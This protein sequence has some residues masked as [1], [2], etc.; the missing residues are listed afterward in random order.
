MPWTYK[1]TTI[2]QPGTVGVIDNSGVSNVVNQNS[3]EVV[4]VGSSGGGVPK[5]VL[6]FTSIDDAKSTL[7]SGEGL[8]AV[9]RAFKPAKDTNTSPGSVSFV[10]VDPATQATYNLVN[11][12]TT[13]LSL[14][15]SQYG[16][17]ANQ[18]ST[19]VQAG[20]LKGL[21]AT[22]TQGTYSKT[23]DN[24]YKGALSIQYLGADASA[25]LTVS[26]SAGQMQGS[27]GA[28][29]AE[30]VAWTAPFATYTKVQDLINYINAQAG[31]S[32]TLMS[33]PSDQATA[34][35]FDD[36]TSQDCKTA[37]YT[38]TSTLD[39]LNAFYNNTGVVTSTRPAGVGTLP[40]VMTAPAY[41]TNGTDG[42]AAN[43]DWSDALATL[44]NHATARIITVLTDDASIHA[45]ADAH[46]SAMSLPGTNQNR[47]Q[48]A[49]GTLGETVSAVLNRASALNSK[50]TSLVYPGIQD[51]DPITLVNTTYAPY[52]VAAQSAGYLASLKITKALT[53]Q[54]IAAKGLEGNLQ[55]TLQSSDYDD[56]VN[57][58]VMAIKY[59]Q[60]QLTGNSYIFDRS[61]TTWLQDT[62]LTNVEISMVCNEDYVDL[63]VV[64]AINAYLVGL[65]GSP[66]GV[67][68][69]ISVID[70]EL[71][72]CFENGAIV[73]DTMKD[74]YSNITVSLANGAVTGGYNATI[75]APMNFFGITAG[76]NI[77]AKT[78][79]LGA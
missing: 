16:A 34:N 21:K 60:N 20:S 70:G 52:M 11:G 68:E 29:G 8:T 45:M 55:F 51:I 61:V 64:D 32:A 24:I 14:K 77:Y 27:S 6:T 30:T 13:V 72:D 9:L 63:R 75:P 74:A 79:T 46:C 10:R 41:F 35:Y 25:L 57:G 69:V 50:R 15:T 38:V 67:G 12:A 3:R 7:V 17:L 1:G 62:K 73:G 31:W 54:S 76:F 19:Q 22:L 44:Q 56:L 28:S 47:V 23:L 26:N 37:A 58:G 18:T 66:V 53:H 4:L 40:T 36:V 42:S 48:I 5:Q 43:Q 78:A 71:R 65:E 2:S 39:A 59:D 49:G 33:A